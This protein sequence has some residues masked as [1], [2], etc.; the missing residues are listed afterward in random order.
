M[1]DYIETNNTFL[2]AIVN[3]HKLIQENQNV[4]ELRDIFQYDELQLPQTPCVSIVF[5]N[6]GPEVMNIGDMGRCRALM[7]VN[8]IIYLYLETLDIG[9]ETKEHIERM[10]ILTEA[11]F[12]KNN[13]YGLCHTEPM[14]IN[15]VKLVGRRI[16]NNE[17]Y[18]AGQ[19]DITVPQRFCAGDLG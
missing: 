18:L 12:K 11:L 13:L 16:A 8:L 6:A 1:P 10:G 3:V 17:I 15:S 19:Y 7:N 4:L 14:T 9:I 5:D 2:N